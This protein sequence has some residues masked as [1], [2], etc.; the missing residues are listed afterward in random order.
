MILGEGTFG[1]VAREIDLQSGKWVAVKY[2]KPSDD[3]GVVTIT[4]VRECDSYRRFVHPHIPQMMRIDERKDTICLVLECAE[5]S[6]YDWLC[7]EQTMNDRLRMAMVALWNCLDVLH[8]VH[9]KNV[10]HRDIKPDNILIR[11]KDVLLSDWGASRIM[12]NKAPGMTPGMGTVYYRPPEM[13]SE[14]YGVPSE[15]YSLGCTI[16]HVLAGS[17]PIIEPGKETISPIQWLNL[18]VKINHIIPQPLVQCIR[19]MISRRYQDR[20]SIP[21]LF[22]HAVFKNCPYKRI[23]Y[24][25]AADVPWPNNWCLHHTSFSE[26]DRRDLIKW[27]ASV[28]DTYTRLA[29]SLVHTVH[30]IDDYHAC[31]HTWSMSPREIYLN[32]IVCCRLVLKYYGCLLAYDTIQE[33][34][35]VDFTSETIDAFEMKI[36]T[37][38]NHRL[39]RRQ[40]PRDLFSNRSIIDALSNAAYTRGVASY[41]P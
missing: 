11:G 38:V 35:C 40:P 31:Q 4:A 36:F 13:D 8:Y 1:V 27:V 26:A 7:G 29:D 34:T 9:S 28:H 12:F 25:Y 3:E 16:L 17:L 20:P 19:S 39:I 10:L 33:R 15:V 32:A 5:I 24:T 37:A 30:L 23:R 14:Y 22:S 2:M 41:A 21:S 6:L 18:L